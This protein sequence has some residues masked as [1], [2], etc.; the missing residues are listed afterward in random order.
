MSYMKNIYEN[1]EMDNDTEVLELIFKDFILGFIKDSEIEIVRDFCQN[2][3]LEFSLST[4]Y[5][6]GGEGAIDL[7][8]KV[9]KVNFKVLLQ[10]YYF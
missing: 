2:N 4:A 9:V 8:Q 1:L 6:D 5:I 3:K 10:N 7:A